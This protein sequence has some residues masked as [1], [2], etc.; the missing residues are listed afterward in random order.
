MKVFSTTFLEPMVQ[1]SQVP[2]SQWK[3]EPAN[4]DMKAIYASGAKTATR[5][6]TY[7]AEKDNESDTDRP[8]EG[9]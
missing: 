8:N 6:T 3:W 4:P 7:A 2:I 5:Q 1:E 9:S